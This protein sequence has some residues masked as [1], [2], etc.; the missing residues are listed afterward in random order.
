MLKILEKAEEWISGILFVIGV[1]IS[2]Y[3]VFMRYILNAPTSWVNEIFEMVMVWS[4]FIG[5]A[6]ALR[7]NHHIAV[8]LLYDKLPYRIKKILCMIGNLLGAL[9][10]IYLAFTGF[11]MTALSKQ[12]DLV[13]ID[14]GMPVWITYAVMPVGMALLSLYFIVKM[15]RAIIGDE[16]EIIGAA[17]KS[18]FLEKYTEEVH[19]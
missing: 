6:I 4:I 8:D 7:H 3:G 15:Y 13:T 12:Q 10:S 2:I 11:Q 17:S 1:A 18:E 14:V 9:Y 16:E 5:F 19:K